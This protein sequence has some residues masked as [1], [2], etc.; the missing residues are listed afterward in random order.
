L[1]QHQLRRLHQQPRQQRQPARR[2]LLSV[3]QL[4]LHRLLW[5]RHRW[6]VPE[7]LR[8]PQRVPVRVRWLQVPEWVS[9]PEQ[10]Y[11]RKR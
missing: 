10:V 11:H 5:R 9:I 1:R 7:Q 6:W 3:H 2:H 4:L 8:E